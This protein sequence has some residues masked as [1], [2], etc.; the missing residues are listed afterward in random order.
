M[1]KERMK[2]GIYGNLFATVENAFQMVISFVLPA[3][4]GEAHWKRDAIKIF[5]GLNIR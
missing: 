4:Y 2:K 5:G 3:T 1:I